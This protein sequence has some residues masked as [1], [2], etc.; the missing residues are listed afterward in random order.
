[1]RSF[2]YDNSAENNRYKVIL[3]FHLVMFVSTC[4]VRLKLITRW[5]DWL[6][7]KLQYNFIKNLFA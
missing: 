4:K 3:R 2:I 1:M 6:E 5:K 7:E